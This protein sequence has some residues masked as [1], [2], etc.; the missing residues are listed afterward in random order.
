MFGELHLAGEDEGVETLQFERRKSRRNVVNGCVTA[1]E[2]PA[3]KGG[4]GRICSLQLQNMSEFGLG[5]MVQEPVALGTSITVFFPP[6]GAERG[7]DVYGH[8]VRCVRRGAAYELGISLRTRA[9]A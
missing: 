8:V 5:A 1:V 9:A 2:S 3:G 7:F 6:H 4:C